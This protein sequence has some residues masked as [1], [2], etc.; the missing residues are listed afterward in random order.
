MPLRA[1]INNKEIIATFLNSE[2]WEILKSEIKQNN[3]DVIL[4]CCKQKGNLRTSKLGLNHF[5]HKPS[6]LTCD[7]KPESPEHLSLKFEILK[8][9]KEC[10]WIAIPEYSENDWRADV[11]AK[12][13]NNRIAF[14]VQ[15]SKQSYE[16]T[17]NRQNK[18]K[19]DKV[20]ACWFFKIIP[21]ELRLYNGDG[22]DNNDIPIFRLTSDTDNV[23]QV[24]FKQNT[25]NLSDFVK[26]LLNKKIK[27]C[28]SYTSKIEQNIEFLFFKTS[29]WKCGMVQHV[30]F[31]DKHDLTS[32]CGHSFYPKPQIEFSF[33][34]SIVYFAERIAS[35]SNGKIILGDIKNR[36]N[37]YRKYSRISFGCYNCDSSFDSFKLSEE[38]CNS[39]GEDSFIRIEKKVLF[40]N[41]LKSDTKHWCFSENK[42]FCE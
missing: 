21:K 11:I 31:I 20:R 8:A 24:S 34:P 7:W 3:Y 6:D 16:E 25:Y 1:T 14:E 40:E 37:A 30:Y 32:N 10:G 5:Y 9:C 4:S 22:I 26:F 35:E 15:L 23:F 36:Y 18:Y 41:L 38:K 33:N 17:I 19:A 39:Y 28:N 27:F 2:E 42:I 12:Q 13:G 29:C